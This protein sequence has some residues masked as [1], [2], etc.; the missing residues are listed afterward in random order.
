[1]QRP[2]LCLAATLTLLRMMLPPAAVLADHEVTV[3]DGD[4]L[5]VIA[6]MWYGDAKYAQQI[7]TYNDLAD[8]DDLVVGQVLKL[9][10]IAGTPETSASVQ[11]GAA[12]G[13][14]WAPSAPPSAP[15]I[16][17]GLAT[18]YGQE[19]EGQ[20]TKCGQ[21]YH[22]AN[23]TASSNDLPCGTVISVTNVHNGRSV[24]VT[25]DDTGDFIHPTILDLSPAA[26]GA[27][28]TLDTGVLPVSVSNA[29]PRNTA[30]L[31]PPSTPQP[32]R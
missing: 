17:M 22:Q 29:A 5:S 6:L 28:A 32:M 2:M 16:Q 31:T 24:T 20:V 25:V 4:T 18:W 9:P 27:L 13:S 3:A 21:V 12:N 26:F 11:G 19:F 10:D 15:V 8:A 14:G 30:V 1:M 7:A 23:Y